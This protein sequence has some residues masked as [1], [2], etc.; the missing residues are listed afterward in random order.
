MDDRYPL[1]NAISG[2]DDLKEMSLAQLDSLAQEL[3]SRIIDVMAI[4]GGHLASNL[5]AVE[6]SIA[7]HR[8]FHSPKDKF[9]FDVGHQSYPHK[10]LTGRNDRFPLIRKYRGLCGFTHP[11]ESPHDHFH[12]GHAGTAISLGLGAATTRD[13][14]GDDH[15]VLPIIG[16]AS[17]TCGLTLEALNNIPRD[18]KRFLVILND[19]AMSISENVGAI[20]NILSRLLNSPRSNKITRELEHLVAKIPAYGTTLAKKG[21]R[22]AETIKNLVSPAPFFDEYGLSYIGPIDGHNLR[23]LINVLE[24]LKALDRPA[25]VHILTKKGQGM[26]QAMK[27]PITYHGAKPFNL[28]TGKF[29]PAT[30]QRPTFPKIFGKHLLAMAEKDESIVAVTPAMLAGS[31]LDAFVQ[32]YPKRCLDVGIAE[33][34]C[35]TFSGGLA[36]SGKHKVVC[37]IYAS[38]LQRAFDNVFHDVCLQELPVVFAVDRGGI[39]GPDGSTHHGIYDIS[40]LNCMPNMIIA[41]PRDGQL[42]AELLTSAFSWNQPTA[43]RYPNM[44]TDDIHEPLQERPLGKGEILAHGEEILIIALGHMCQTALQVRQLLEKE[45]LSATV[46]DPIFV[47]PLDRKLLLELLPNHHRIITLEEHSLSGGLGAIINNFLVQENRHHLHQVWNF[48]IPNRFVGHGSYKDLIQELQL[49]PSQIVD[50]LRAEFS[51]D[52]ERSYTPVEG[53]LLC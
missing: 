43:I 45:G 18:L 6:M 16:D 46:V 33:G 32:K 8:V 40:F 3:R 22:L 14:Q 51:E 31:C 13:L 26:S 27:N 23:Q 21:H 35:V 48:G 4:N 49:T 7:L 47:K 38:F 24:A 25:I 17:L 44:E 30:S 50:R 34:H 53:H 39:S 37:S 19:N 9:I 42:L 1:L 10:L 12:S 52:K 20:T 11:K 29:L 15:F 36:S 2:P 5:G 41:Q 28:E